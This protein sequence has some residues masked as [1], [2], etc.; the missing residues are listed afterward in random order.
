M[1]STRITGEKILVAVFT[2]SAVSLSFFSVA[3]AAKPSTEAVKFALVETAPN[4]VEIGTPIMVTIEARSANN[5]VDPAYQQD[6]TL[7]LDGSATGG[8]LVDIVNG[9][10]TVE[11][12]DLAAEDVNISLSDTMGTGLDVSST[13]KVKFKNI[14]GGPT[15]TPSE[16]GAGA[17]Q[18]ILAISGKAFP[19]AQITLIEKGPQGDKLTKKDIIV[20]KDGNFQ[21]TI[22]QI[23][24]GYYAYSLII[25]DKD[26]RQTQTK[27]FGADFVNNNSVVIKD[28]LIPPSI[29]LARIV[30]TQGDSVK[31]SGCASPNNLVKVELD[32]DIKYEAKANTEGDYELFINTA[33]LNFGRH[34]IRATQ[35]DAVLKKDSDFSL[36]KGFLVSESGVPKADLSGDGK[37]DIK[38]W[39]IFL[40]LWK[41]KNLEADLDGNGKIDISDLSI[42]LRGIRVKI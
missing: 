7:V 27:T 23:P 29:S 28:I 11:I 33:R 22:N 9:T 25:K 41:D 5:K 19:D 34:E 38:D 26:G 3:I 36:T 4:T 1:K 35:T 18:T 2:L 16:A 12:N 42:L 24:E 30:V 37:I 15:P 6:V 8:G 20:P 13:R 40:S 17:R 10:A 21:I 39:S 31:I 14:P 32:N